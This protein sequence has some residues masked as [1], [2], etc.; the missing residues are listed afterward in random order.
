MAWRALCRA[1]PVILPCALRWGEMDA[2][3]H[4][5]NAAYFRLFEDARIA[6]FRALAKALPPPPSSEPG[7]GAD[8]LA[9]RGPAAPIL[10][11]TSCRFKFP[12]A[13][14]DALFLG[15]SILPLPTEANNTLD[16]FAMKYAVF[17]V[18]RGAV[19]A[20]GTADVRLYAYEEGR[21]AELAQNHPLFAA[22]RAVEGVATCRGEAEE[23]RLWAAAAGSGAV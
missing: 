21:R 9:G 14:P 18:A 23:A 13:F 22:V 3:Q 19:A 5:N 15:S 8:F 10:A 12:L 7:F 4:L 20:E 11:S 2:F 6:H 1:H 17:S 16:R